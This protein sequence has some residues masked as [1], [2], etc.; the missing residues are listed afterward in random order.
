MRRVRV[1]VALVVVC[2][3]L[4]GLTPTWG[5]G[6]ES[7]EHS[8]AGADGAGPLG[9]DP[10]AGSTTPGDGAAGLTA[11]EPA[12][13]QN[14]P[15]DAAAPSYLE[16]YSRPFR[17]D[18]REFTFTQKYYW[19]RLFHPTPRDRAIGAGVLAGAFSLW[20]HKSRSWAVGWSFRPR[21][22]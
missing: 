8:P 17:L 12:D 13:R 1:R 14:T 22:S 4:L 11:G 5:S 3:F 18:T 21:R 10:A 19:H 15:R 20:T 9:Q 7:L 16:W 2:G 6:D